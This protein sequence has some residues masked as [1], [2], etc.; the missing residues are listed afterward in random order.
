MQRNMH[1][2]NNHEKYL[3][4]EEIICYSNNKKRG[5]QN[6]RTITNDYE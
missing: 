5:P 6:A 4:V 1:P 3:A 2:N